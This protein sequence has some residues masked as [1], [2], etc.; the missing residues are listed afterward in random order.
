MVKKLEAQVSNLQHELKEQGQRLGTSKATAELLRLKE[1]TMAVEL[2]H[3]KS[4]M[5]KV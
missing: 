5:V 2:S 4:A 1:E 3:L